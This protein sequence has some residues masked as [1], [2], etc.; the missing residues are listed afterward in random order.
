MIAV[1][2][3]KLD[4]PVAETKRSPGPKLSDRPPANSTDD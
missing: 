2:G 1:S 3:G 4:V